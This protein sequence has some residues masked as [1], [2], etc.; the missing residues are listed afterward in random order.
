[1]SSGY[2]TYLHGFTPTSVVLSL[3]ACAAASCPGYITRRIIHPTIA[4]VDS[5]DY[6][7]TL[8]AISLSISPAGR[9]ESPAPQEQAEFVCADRDSWQQN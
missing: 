2:V 8:S 5:L 4:S 9:V 7:R 1:M 6:H 3:A